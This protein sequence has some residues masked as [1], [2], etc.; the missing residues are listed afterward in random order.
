MDIRAEWIERAR[1]FARHSGRGP[2]DGHTYYCLVALRFTENRDMGFDQYTSAIRA[3]RE[4][5]AIRADPQLWKV[6]V[7]NAEYISRPDA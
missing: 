1:C 5:D 7:A 6:Q 3:V 2:A 4:A